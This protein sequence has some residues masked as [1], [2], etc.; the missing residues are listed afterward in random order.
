MLK[1]DLVV[2]KNLTI[3]KNDIF[4]N[5][6]NCSNWGDIIKN[7]LKSY[8]NAYKNEFDFNL[9]TSKTNKSYLIMTDNGG[10]KKQVFKITMSELAS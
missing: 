10:E 8:V 5:S 3:K 7:T 1:K 9:I 6:E 2:N 4:V